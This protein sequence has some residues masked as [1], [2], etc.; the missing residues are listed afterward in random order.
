MQN[1]VHVMQLFCQRCDALQ[2]G[3]FADHQRGASVGDL[4]AQKLA[5]ECRVDRHAYCA[6]LVDG[7]PGDDRIDIVVEH[8]QYSFT[9]LDAERRQGVGHSCRK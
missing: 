6:Q 1:V 2:V 8:G 4:V 7:Q 3:S 9:R 5:L